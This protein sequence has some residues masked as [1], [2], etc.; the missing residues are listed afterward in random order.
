MGGAIQGSPLSL[1]TEVTT[2][3]G[4]GNQTD[5]EDGTADG[6]GTNATFSEPYGITTDGTNLYVSDMSNHTIRKLIIATGEVTTLA[7]SG[8]EGC[9]DGSGTN[10]TFERG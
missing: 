9:Q 1:S 6:V 10:A 8:S 2:F 3:A 4:S 7:G 5:S